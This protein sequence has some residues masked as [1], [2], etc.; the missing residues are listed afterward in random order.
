MKNIIQIAIGAI[1]IAI[2]RSFYLKQDLVENIKNVTVV[3]VGF[4]I[5]YYLTNIVYSFCK[6][7]I[8]KK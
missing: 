1:I 4:A 7:K 5:I 6:N 8:R 2:I 3:I